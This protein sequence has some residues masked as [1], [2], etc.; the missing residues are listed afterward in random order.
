MNMTKADYIFFSPRWS[1]TSEF[2]FLLRDQE[3]TPCP[4]C[5]NATNKK[6]DSSGHADIPW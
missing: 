6:T 5:N 2:F 1:D 4:H 3:V